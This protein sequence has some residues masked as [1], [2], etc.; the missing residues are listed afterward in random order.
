MLKNVINTHTEL[1]HTHS[2]HC[3]TPYYNKDG[4]DDVRQ[5]KLKKFLYYVVFNYT[6]FC[7]MLLYIIIYNL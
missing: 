7:Y 2:T 4:S 6:I 3:S 5:Q 1:Q